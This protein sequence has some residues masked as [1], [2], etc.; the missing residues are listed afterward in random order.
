MRRTLAG[1]ALAVVA[2]PAA[3]AETIVY[4]N[5]QNTKAFTFAGS[6]SAL[7]TADGPSS[8]LCPTPTIVRA[9]SI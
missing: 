4:K 2:L 1:I 3:R 6:A 8:G 9:R 7:T 5:F